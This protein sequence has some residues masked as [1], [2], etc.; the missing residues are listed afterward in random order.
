MWFILCSFFLFAGPTL[1]ILVNLVTDVTSVPNHSE[2]QA[3][4]AFL[5][6]CSMQCFLALGLGYSIGALSS[7]TKEETQENIDGGIVVCSSEE[8]G[9]GKEGGV[10]SDVVV[11]ISQGRWGSGSC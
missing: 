9:P 1:G 2:V 4:V 5:L 7:P 3:H 8:E 6:I 11:G 10:S